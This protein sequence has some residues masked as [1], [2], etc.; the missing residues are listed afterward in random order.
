MKAQMKMTKSAKVAVNDAQQTLKE[1]KLK[2]NEDK[3]KAKTMGVP[4]T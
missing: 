4:K 2:Q 3:N 1:L